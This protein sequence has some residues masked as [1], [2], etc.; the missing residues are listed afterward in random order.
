MKKHLLLIISFLALFTSCVD[1]KEYPN[2]PEGNF[3]ALW[4]IIDERYCFFDYKHEA[5]GLDWQNVYNIYKVRANEDIN[6]YQ[7]FEI[8]T[9][10]LS[11]LRDGHVNLSTSFDYGRYWKWHEDYPTNFSDTLQRRYLGTDYHIASS[12]NYKIFDDNIG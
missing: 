4:K 9:E 6:N 8:L 1:E 7:L 12:I 11:E 5:Y 10:M 2:T 3:E